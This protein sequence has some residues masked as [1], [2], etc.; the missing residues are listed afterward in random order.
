MYGY[1]NN[2]NS[3]VYRY[4]RTA[5]YFGKLHCTELYELTTFSIVLS[6]QWPLKVEVLLVLSYISETFFHLLSPDILKE[7]TDY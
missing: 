3:L 7:V 5:P 6:V 1:E 2:R 4:T